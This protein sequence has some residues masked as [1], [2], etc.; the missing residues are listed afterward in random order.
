VTAIGVLCAR[1]RVE[2]K[3]IITALGDAGAVG[4]PVPPTSTP[5]PPSPALQQLAALGVSATGNQDG[6]GV[7]PRVLIDRC[8]NRSV[9]SAMLQL[10]HGSGM[11]L[12]DAGLAATGTRPQVA[13]ALALAGLPRPS[14]LVA[15]SEPS[16]IRATADLGYPSTLLPITPG[17]TTTCL[18]DEDTAEAVIEHRVVLGDHTEAIVLLQS[19]APAQHE[20]TRV[21]VV[22][23]RAIAIDGDDA[24]AEAI[25][26]A[27]QAAEVLGAS[28]I[29]IDIACIEGACVVWDALP[30][31]DFRQS[32]LLGATSV[33]E[34]LAELAL[35]MGHER[36]SALA[37]PVG[38]EREARHGIVLSA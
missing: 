13:S 26:L 16:G 15:F 19:G 27:E 12:I 3:Q 8:Q 10:L 20:L 38:W 32:T 37:I 34:A 2:E 17:S 23:G 21:H 7:A 35:S 29:A 25:R 14:S 9:A 30:V 31:A 28:L 11:H 1:V 6:A 18:L 33:G 22:G 24:N 4:M 36:D 5:L